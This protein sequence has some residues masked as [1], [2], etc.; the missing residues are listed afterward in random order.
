MPVAWR[1]MPLVRHAVIHMTRCTVS[2]RD[3]PSAWCAMPSGWRATPS[4]WR[5][6]HQHVVLRHQRVTL[7]H[8]R[9]TLR[10]LRGT[11]CLWRGTLLKTPYL[12][13]LKW[14][15]LWVFVF[16]GLIFFIKKSSKWNLAYCHAKGGV[17]LYL[18]GAAVKISQAY[19]LGTACLQKR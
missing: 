6:C 5:K 16:F 15:Y 18:A 17:C 9:G 19:D 13:T 10:R 1:G 2:W 7:R 12:F 11:F 4:A 14:P 8:P 3:T